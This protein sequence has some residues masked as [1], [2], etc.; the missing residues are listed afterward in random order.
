MKV[1]L[2]LI[3]LLLIIHLSSQAQ[4]TTDGTLG[5]SVNLPG[6]HYKIG[7][8]LGQQ[9]GSHLFHSFQEFNIQKHQTASF[10][11]P[12]T[13]ENIISRVTGEQ[14]SHINGL[15]RSTQP[16]IDLYFLNPKGIIFGPHARLDIQGSFHASTA[17]YLRLGKTGQ[18]NARHPSE[19]L[20]SIAPIEAFGFLSDSPASLSLEQNQLTVPSHSSLSLISGDLTLKSSTLTAGHINLASFAK[21]G[22]V[23]TLFDE[24]AAPALGGEIKLSDQS[25]INVSGEGSG[26]VFIRSGQFIAENS[27]I[28]ADT[29]GQQAGYG[30][31][32]Q[33]KEMTINNQ[34]QITSHTSGKG[35]AG[36]ISINA[37]NISLNQY[38]QITSHTSDQGNAGS[39]SINARNISLND[40]SGIISNTS[41]EGKAGPISINVD[42]L[43]LNQS[44]IGSDTQSN[45]EAN[46]VVIIAK[47]KIILEGNNT[48]VASGSIGSSDN[49]GNAA[50]VVLRSDEIFVIG[51]GIYSESNTKGKAGQIIIE[52]NNLFIENGGKLYTST[53]GQG[54]AGHIHINA[55][56]TVSLSGV[57]SDGLSSLIESG[58]RAIVEKSGKGGDIF[59]QSKTLILKGGGQLSVSSLAKNNT[60]SGLAGKIILQI[61]DAITLSGVNPYGENERGFGAGIYA[62]SLG[63]QAGGGGEIQLSAAS[64]TIKE[65]AVIESSTTG[66]APGGHI[67]IDISGPIYIT[68]DATQ[69]ELL[70]PATTQKLYLEN[71]SPRTYNQSTSGIYAN[72]NSLSEQGGIGGNITLTAQKL[73]LTD[74]AR[75]S[76]TTAGT[77]EAGSI[78]ISVEQLQLDNTA[79]II[80]DSQFANTFQSPEELI[81]FGDVV[82][83]ENEGDGKIGR[84]ISLNNHLVVIA[85]SIDSVAHRAQLE[86]LS[87][88]Y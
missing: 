65:G 49:I 51:G 81:A 67:K 15:I 17:D 54:D 40:E 19:S 70:A 23:K 32:I 35:N 18:F 63:E 44:Q 68:G 14:P 4:I 22:E 39:I 79:K 62:R 16:K 27:K 84:R 42:N 1:K 26:R 24:T 20:L 30:I 61:K 10:Y 69:I 52:A 36:S 64:L 38:S 48:W 13:V 5:S 47:E 46:Q 87:H 71:F 33:V 50:Q 59:I 11:A 6:P 37:D 53:S 60:Q 2:R 45:G 21:A 75:I 77:G 9:H 58:S 66:I 3:I 80:S 88:Q 56:Q 72:S 57:N 82:E 12:N 83:I 34:S 7:A 74:K 85:S 25:M 73:T 29:L 8:N 78:I 86:Q 55:N 28:Y 31:D 76:T 43:T 41:H